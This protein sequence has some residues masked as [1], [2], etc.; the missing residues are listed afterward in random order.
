MGRSLISGM[1]LLLFVPALASADLISKS[2]KEYVPAMYDYDLH[3]R[4]ADDELAKVHVYLDEFDQIAF[5]D[6]YKH[7]MTQI[8]DQPNYTPVHEAKNSFLIAGAFLVMMTVMY[9]RKK[10]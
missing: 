2:E 1:I 10:K 9:R 4:T 3:V 7:D 5:A 6:S 8:Y